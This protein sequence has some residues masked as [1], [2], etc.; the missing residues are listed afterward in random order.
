MGL[1][2]AKA[3]VARGYWVERA[4]LNCNLANIYEIALDH[5]GGVLVR[6]EWTPGIGDPT[7]TG[8]YTVAAYFAAAALSWRAARLARISRLQAQRIVLFW[9]FVAMST[10]CLG[11]NKQLD[12]QSL[13]TDIA[14]LVSKEYGWYAH[15][16]GVQTSAIGMIAAL[17]SAFL[18]CLLF[19]FRNAAIQ[20]R[21]ASVGLCF[22]I[23]FV[24]ARAVS[25]HRV[26]LLISTDFYGIPWNAILELPGIML[27]I[28]AALAFSAKTKADLKRI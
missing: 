11:I 8:W 15:R 5:I 13:L 17:G 19:Y 18:I 21:A 12:I 10:L 3:V 24:V 22:V 4:L 6:I 28:G 9:L 20:V 16:R 25:F 27:I 14:R 23:C 26:D 1:L 2:N 7:I